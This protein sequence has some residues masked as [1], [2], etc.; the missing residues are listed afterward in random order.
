ML[1]QTF[2]H[3]SLTKRCWWAA[4]WSSAVH[5]SQTWVF[6]HISNVK[7]NFKAGIVLLILKIS[8]THNKFK[9]KW[10]SSC[11]SFYQSC[12]TNWV[13]LRL[14]SYLWHTSCLHPPDNLDNIEQQCTQTVC[15]FPSYPASSG[16]CHPLHRWTHTSVK[17]CN[18]FALS[19]R[20]AGGKKSIRKALFHCYC[21]S[22]NIL[23]VIQNLRQF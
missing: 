5:I 11:V 7:C 15:V 1:S 17:K 2:F 13:W 8:P 4:F 12:P 19:W 18:Q 6:R 3:L 20:P 21:C 22:Q 10:K 14:R 16:A 23:P 9:R